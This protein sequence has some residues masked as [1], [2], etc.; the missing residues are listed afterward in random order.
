M[1]DCQYLICQ[2]YCKCD[3]VKMCNVKKKYGLQQQKYP[4]TF[5]DLQSL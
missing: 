3:N 4:N 5:T 1:Y 2:W